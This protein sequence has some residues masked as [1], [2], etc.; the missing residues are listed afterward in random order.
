MRI[1]FRGQMKMKNHPRANSVPCAENGLGDLPP[2]PFIIRHIWRPCSKKR[3]WG[4]LLGCLPL[5]W[6][7]AADLHFSGSLLKFCTAIFHP[8]WLSSSCLH[9]GGPVQY[10]KEG[11]REL[12][13]VNRWMEDETFCQSLRNAEMLQAVEDNARAWFGGSSP[14][15]GTDVV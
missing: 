7:I 8:N 5:I 10:S 15:L 11:G 1:N 14:N 12:V 6:R 4:R 2:P 3:V 9:Q 13:A